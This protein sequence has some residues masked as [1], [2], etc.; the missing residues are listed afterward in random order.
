MITPWTSADPTITD[1]E[2]WTQVGSFFAEIGVE[3][4]PRRWASSSAP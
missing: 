2:F 1:P 4:D 3:H